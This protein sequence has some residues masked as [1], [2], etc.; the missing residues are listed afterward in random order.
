MAQS[1]KYLLV[2]SI[3]AY[4]GKS[5]TILGIAQQLRE[6]GLSIAYSKPLAT[7][8]EDDN[9]QLE[10]ADVDFIARALGLK[11]T[12]ISLP[13]VPLTTKSVEKRLAGEDSTNVA[14]KPHRYCS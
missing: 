3:E 14:A 13:L 12:H 5:G 1:A 2:G 11:E 8:F 4:S 6:K 7:C 10:D 9:T